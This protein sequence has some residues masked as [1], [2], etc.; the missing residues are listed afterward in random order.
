MIFQ[1]RNSRIRRHRSC[2][3]PQRNRRKLVSKSNV[4]SNQLRI[5]DE[6][7][8]VNPVMHRPESHALRLRENR[9]MHRPE[10][11]GNPCPKRL[12]ETKSRGFRDGKRLKPEGVRASSSNRHPK[13]L[14]RRWLQRGRRG[15]RGELDLE[16]NTQSRRGRWGMAAEIEIMDCSI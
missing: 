16:G 13:P 7:R 10:N 15:I 2:H 3:C 14:Q 8:K 6:K 1:I 11:P 5:R 12:H 9:E 4:P